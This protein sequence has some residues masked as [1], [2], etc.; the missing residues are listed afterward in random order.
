MVALPAGAAGNLFLTTYQVRKV[1]KKNTLLKSC[2][3]QLC[4]IF[5]HTFILS[6]ELGRVAAVEDVLHRPSAEDTAPQGAQQ[7]QAGS[8]DVSSDEDAGETHPRPLCIQH[9]PAQAAGGQAVDHHL[10]T[11]ILEYL[12]QRPQFVTK[13]SDDSAAVGL[14]TDGDDT[15]YRGL[16]QNFVDW[17]LRDNLQINASKTKELHHGQGQE[18]EGQLCPGMSPGLSG[19]GGKQEDDG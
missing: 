3:N 19:G 7:L 10:R 8:S 17:S 4:G 14:I 6:L 13:F 12:T 1:L 16:I 5:S 15:E 2:A 18:E 11:W 9:H